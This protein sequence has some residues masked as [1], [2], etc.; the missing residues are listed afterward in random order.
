M[1]VREKLPHGASRTDWAQVL[2]TIGGQQLSSWRENLKF[3]SNF[4][5][6]RW[7]RG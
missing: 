3:L 2:G 1:I 6:V 4:N 5:A 7:P